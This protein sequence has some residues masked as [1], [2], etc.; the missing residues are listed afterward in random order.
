MQVVVDGLLTSY[1]QIGG[2]SKTILFLHGWADKGATF[3]ELAIQIT[4]ANSEYVAILLDLPGFGSTQIPNNA[5]GL[6]EYAQFVSQ[7][8]KKTGLSPECIIGHSNG[9]AIAVYGLSHGV[10]DTRQLV[11]IGSA[12]IRD[13][14]IKKDAMRIASKPVKWALKL[15]PNRVQRK[16]RQRIY[17]A[18]GSDYL[19]AEHLQETFKRVVSYDVRQDAQQVSIPVRLIYGKNDTATPPSY[20]QQLSECIPDSN[21]T[22]LPQSGHFVHQEQASKVASIISEFM[23]GGPQ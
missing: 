13:K 14:S 8:I 16:I 18:I 5:W 2:G 22:I 19:V 17:G 7:F 20:G 4:Q 11:L 23:K 10:F 3:N 6:P 12:G 21:L 15:A 9:G 1:N